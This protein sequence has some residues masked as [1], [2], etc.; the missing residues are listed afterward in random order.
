MKTGIELA[1]YAFSKI[2][3]PYFYGAKMQILTDSFMARMKA[4]YPSMVTSRYVEK[5]RTKGLV[6]KICVDCSGLIGSYRGKQIGSAQLYSSA[7]KRLKMDDLECFPIGTV[8]WKKGHV[9]V[10]IGKEKGV[11]MCVEA[12]GIDYGTILSKLSAT[13][14]QYGLL[15]DDMQYTNN[16]PIGETKPHNP[17]NEPTRNISR[18][19]K[20]TDVKW[21][22]FE[23]VEAGYSLSID[24][25]AGPITEKYIREFQRSAKLKVDG[26]CGKNTRKALLVN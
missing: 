14:W 11:P 9:G 19:C 5:A 10:Y 20:G 1:E 17:Y 25:K 3:T 7:S 22:Q 18:S 13:K 15:F 23:L 2:G 21:V 24:G 8:L 26:I 16:V 4:N 12:K 6:G